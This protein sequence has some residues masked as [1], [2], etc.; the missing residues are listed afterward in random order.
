[1]APGLIRTDFSKAL[2]ENKEVL[3]RRLAGT[4]LGRVG[5]PGDVGKT[6]VGCENR[7]DNERRRAPSS[8]S[9]R[10]CAGPSLT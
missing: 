3:A 7:V 5:E 4:P 2:I 10:P 6:T 9:L 8:T 1:V